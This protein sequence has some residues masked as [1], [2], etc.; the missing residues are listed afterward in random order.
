MPSSV[1]ILLEREA[2]A[3]A[4]DDEGR[5]PLHWLCTLPGKY[6]E[7]QQQAF[8]KLV[9]HGPAAINMA[10]KQGRKPLH[11]AL[12]A[13]ADRSQESPFAIKHLVSAGANANEPDPVT[14]DSTLHQLAPRLVGQAE[15]AAEATSLFRELSANLDINARNLAQETP[16][17]AFARAGWK[18]TWDPERKIS[19]PTY[20]LAN[21]INHATA[22]SVFIDLGVDLM[23]VD[24]RGQTLLHVT[25]GRE[26]VGGSWESDQ[27]EDLKG[28]F[29]KLMELGLDP[30]KEDAELRTAIDIAVAR[31]VRGVMELFRE[32]VKKNVEE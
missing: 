14:G 16:V 12:L 17:M 27:R 20:A 6:D 10:D 30:R 9:E 15:R 2:D 1:I 3:L 22:L 23:A 29:Q 25:A 7:E 18:G 32:K 28:M 11:L 21:D 4:V 31:D 8:I 19:H 5:T 24:A 13:Y 26:P